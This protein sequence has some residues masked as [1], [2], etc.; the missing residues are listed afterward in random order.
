MVSRFYKNI[1]R[2]KSYEKSRSY[3]LKNKERVLLNRHIDRD[4]QRISKEFSYIMGYENMLETLRY[5]KKT[6]CYYSYD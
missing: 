3:Y 4:F 5:I 2:T 1:P 6:Y